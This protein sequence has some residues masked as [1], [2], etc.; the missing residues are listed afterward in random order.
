MTTEYIAQMA[1]MWMTAGLMV[2][3]LA[4][5]GWSEGGSGLLTDLGFGLAGGVAAGA[6]IRT[7]LASDAGMLASFAIG[8]V[9]A[10]AA[11]VGQRKLWR[12]SKSAASGARSGSAASAA[13]AVLPDRRA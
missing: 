7:A 1:P 6:L 2:A 4:D 10:I 5:A 8:G 3:W 11:I 12:P 13:S 9:G